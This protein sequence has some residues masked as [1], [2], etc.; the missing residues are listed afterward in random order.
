M[1]PLR[2]LILASLLV[3]CAAQTAAAVC[4]PYLEYIDLGA[5]G[6]TIATNLAVYPT[7]QSNPVINTPYNPTCTAA[8]WRAVVA[9]VNVPAGCAG[10]EVWVQ[11]DGEPQG[12]TLDVGDSD[13]DNGFG[14]DSGSLPAGQNAELQIVNDNLSVYSASSN[15][16]DL[17]QL[18]TQQL[19]LKDGALN[20]AVKDQFVSWGEPYSALSTPVTQQLFFLPA[21]AG[22]DRTIYVGLNRVILPINGQDTARNG[23]GA[24]RAILVLR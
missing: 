12:F 6:G 17:V 11:Y 24:R 18:A 10:V 8:L 21:T 4:T 14:G 3:P 20:V 22:A 19:A 5:G 15:A 2:A 23:C 9:Q 7:T 16:A 1:K 13:T